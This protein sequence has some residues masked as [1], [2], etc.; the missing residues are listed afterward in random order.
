MKMPDSAEV[1][2]PLRQKAVSGFGVQWA[3]TVLTFFL[4]Q[5]PWQLTDVTGTHGGAKNKP[6]NCNCT[7]SIDLFLDTWNVVYNFLS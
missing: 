3:L 7:L 2:N 4:F 5:F 6:V 1:K